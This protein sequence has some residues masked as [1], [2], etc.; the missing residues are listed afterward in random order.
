MAEYLT[1]QHG[2][3]AVAGVQNEILPQ[4]CQKS[5]EKQEDNQAHANGGQGALGLMH[6]HLVDNHLRE[7][8]RGEAHQLQYQRG[9][10]HITPDGF[11]LQEFGQKP[12]KAEFLRV[13][14]PQVVIG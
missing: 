3:D 9:D 13:A 1:A 8:R 4:P 5:V 12:A 14:R 2:I 7:Q 10:Q 6:H 11:V